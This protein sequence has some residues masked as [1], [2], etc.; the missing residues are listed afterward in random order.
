[1][2]VC[3][4]V[5]TMLSGFPV[6]SYPMDWKY[7]GEVSPRYCRQLAIEMTPRLKREGKTVRCECRFRDDAPRKP[8]G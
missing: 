3:I 7:F 8:A 6:R 2:D 1:M 4:L 5:V